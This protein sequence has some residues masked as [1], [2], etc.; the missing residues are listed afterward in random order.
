MSEDKKR[1]PEEQAEIDARMA[2]LREAKANKAKQETDETAA[3]DAVVE[4]PVEEK[5]SAVRY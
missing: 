4:E 2:K 5:E 3:A 1:T